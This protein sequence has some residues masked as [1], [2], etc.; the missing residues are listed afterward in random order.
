MNRT[1][2]KPV[3]PLIQIVL[4]YFD[5]ES[6][7]PSRGLISK[8]E[9]A[10]YSS[11]DTNNILRVLSSPKLKTASRDL[12]LRPIKQRGRTI[13]AMY[14]LTHIGEMMLREVHSKVVKQEEV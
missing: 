4:E 7:K 11:Y 8:A 12:D 6:W 9:E 5:E 2:E 14:Q 10:G 3:P 13:G 1:I